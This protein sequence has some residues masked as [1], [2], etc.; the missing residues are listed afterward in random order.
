MLG[1]RHD[2]L[3]VGAG[4][5]GLFTAL[6]LARRGLRINVIDREWREAAHSYG[7]A[8]HPGSLRLLD[9]VGVIAPVLERGYRVRKIRLFDGAAER[10]QV[11]VSALGVDF[12]FVPVVRQDVLESILLHALGDLGVKVHWNHRLAEIEPKDDHLEATIEHL[13]KMSTGY[14]M[15]HTEWVVRKAHRAKTAYVIGTDGH[16]S[17]VR[18]MCGIDFP[19]AGPTQN[20]A[21]CE[22]DSDFDAD[23][24]MSLVLDEDTTNVLWPLPNG[25]CRWSL[26]LTE[27]TPDASRDKSRLTVQIGEQTYPHLGRDRLEELLEQRAPWFRGRIGEIHWS[28]AVR[29]ERRLAERFGRERGGGAPP[30]TWRIVWRASSRR[31]NRPACCT[32]MTTNAGPSGARCWNWTADWSPSTPPTPG[33]ASAARESCRAC[34]RRATIW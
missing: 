24:A 4:P 34:L 30:A 31:A 11:N 9:E 7:L 14:A 12:P 2:V 15:A 33:F 26:E 20:F 29:F 13:E 25:R 6:H 27:S 8:L 32:I 3:I 1:R 28:M 19:H 17:T 18:H 10:A 21:V 23:G 16:H 5:V 22:F